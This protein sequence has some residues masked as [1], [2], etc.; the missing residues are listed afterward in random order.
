MDSNMYSTEPPVGLA[1][2]A[3]AV[4]ALAAQDL[5]RLTDAEAAA[6]VLA[7]RGL[8]ERL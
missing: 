1:A 7:L 2:L 6:G 5:T 4:E 8:L 3:S